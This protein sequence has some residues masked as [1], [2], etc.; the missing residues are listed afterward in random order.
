MTTTPED[1]PISG[2]LRKA[3]IADLVYAD[4]RDEYDIEELSESMNTPSDWTRCL[5]RQLG[6]RWSSAE[7]AYETLL[8]LIY[9]IDH[10]VGATE[11]PPPTDPADCKPLA[12]AAIKGMS[13]DE[14]YATLLSGGDRWGRI[15]LRTGCTLEG[16][17][18]E[19]KRILA[20]Q[21]AAELAHLFSRWIDWN[22]RNTTKIEERRRQILREIDEAR[23]AVAAAA[24][25]APVPRTPRTQAEVREDRKD[26]ED[27]RGPP[28]QFVPRGRT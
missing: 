26:L 10:M 7:G 16:L 5:G 3:L 8:F 15:K 14:V 19:L 2:R 25:P 4:E 23:E 20:A 11:W 12:E 24:R 22:I 9:E 13:G 18:S 28:F 27:R 17:P 1:R 21:L 6:F